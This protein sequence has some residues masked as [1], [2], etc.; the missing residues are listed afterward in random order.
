MCVCV[1][2]FV[3]YSSS[4]PTVL[5]SIDKGKFLDMLKGKS[6]KVSQIKTEC[7]PQFCS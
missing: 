3:R 1:Y 2:I 7:T 6:A 5:K 4:L